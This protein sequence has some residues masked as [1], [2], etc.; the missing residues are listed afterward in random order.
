MTR[1]PISLT[2]ACACGLSL[3][4]CGGDDACPEPAFSEPT[5]PDGIETSAEGDVVVVTW[6]R[7]PGDPLPDAYYAE[8]DL[9][10]QTPDSGPFPVKS[11]VNTAPRELTLVFSP[12]DRVREQPRDLSLRFQ[13]PD[14]MDWTDCSHPGQADQYYVSLAVSFDGKGSVTTSF[15]DVDASHGDCSVGTGHRHSLLPAALLLLGLAALM[16]RRRGARQPVDIPRP[17]WHPRAHG[18]GG[19]RA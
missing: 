7:T 10:D 11:A 18:I 4:G 1:A 13:M 15:S 17:P 8:M 14:T 9:Y 16:R 2:L 3:S 12:L 19:W 5:V 6:P